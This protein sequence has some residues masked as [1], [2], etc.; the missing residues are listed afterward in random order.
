MQDDL[1]KVLGLRH[2]PE[3]RSHLEH[4]I[5]EA[6]RHERRGAQRN[7]GLIGIKRA[8]EAFFDGII[9]PAP[10]YSLAVVLFAAL[11]LGFYGDSG[12]VLLEGGGGSQDISE[13]LSLGGEMDFGEVL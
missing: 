11:F 5:I 12:F 2:V 13:Y 3:M 9:L 10:A 6:S 7:S 1:D 8:V 4:R